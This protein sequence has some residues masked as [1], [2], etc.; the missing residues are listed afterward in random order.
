MKKIAYTIVSLGAALSCTRDYVVPGEVPSHSAVYTSEADFGNKVQVNGAMTFADGSPGI[1]ERKW[2]FPAGVDI[3][4]CDNDSTSGQNK[5]K[6]VFKKAG[7]FEVKLNQK[8]QGNAYINGTFR[9]TEADTTL[10]ITVLDSVSVGV[11]AQKLDKNG[12]V[13]GEL[14]IRPQAFNEVEAGKFIQLTPQ[15]V[16]EPETVTWILEGADPAVVT[17][18]A[19][20]KVRYKKLGTYTVKLVA[21]RTRPGGGD[22]LEL[23]GLIRV[24]PSSDPVTLDGVANVMKDASKIALNFSRDM[25][26]STLT[27]ANF[28]V[29]VT[30]KGQSIATQ[31]RTIALDPARENVV[32]LGLSAPIYNDDEVKVSYTKGSLKT[33]DGVAA[34]AFANK[35]VVFIKN[36]L[37]KE[38]VFDE[39]FEN[40]ENSN[41]PYQSW[42]APWDAYKID[43][44]REESYTGNKSLKI[45]LNPKGGMI[46]GHTMA[47]SPA[48]FKAQAGKKYEIGFWAKVKSIGSNAAGT[49]NPNLTFFWE[50]GTNWAAG[51][52]EFSADTPLNQWVYLRVSYAEFTADGN[53]QFW[54]R[55]FNGNNT[56]PLVLYMDEISIAE[57]KLRP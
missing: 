22:T 4:E 43:V 47:G 31:A 30:N 10:R 54:I 16:G 15:L 9:G 13:A 36:N 26:A 21:S 18:I 52:Y 5:L 41:W 49:E 51:R 53:F 34:D 46:I 35:P 8:F 17:S 57:V 37:L 39:G 50:P 3:L 11:K 12:A 25:D 20:V 2:V 19:P 24:V 40:S 38:G 33:S 28:W 6:V 44:T 1:T 48:R 56:K 14:A 27:P 29:S 7:V 45:E 55:G 32:L 23:P 42:G